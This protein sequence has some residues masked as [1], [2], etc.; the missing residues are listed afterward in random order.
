MAAVAGALVTVLLTH[1]LGKRR[2]EPPPSVTNHFYVTINNPVKT[3][4]DELDSAADKDLPL[5]DPD[6]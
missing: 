1:V 4:E 5:P 2:R 6:S 3:D